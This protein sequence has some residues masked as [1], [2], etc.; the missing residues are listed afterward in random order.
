MKDKLI[1]IKLVRFQTEM[2][3]EPMFK[4]VS[5]T[6]ALSLPS[7]VGGKIRYYPGDLI[8]LESARN[9]V[10]A[11]DTYEVTVTDK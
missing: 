8:S 5:L 10:E 1:K 7:Y 3:G 6:G 2:R 4:L 11:F 9:W